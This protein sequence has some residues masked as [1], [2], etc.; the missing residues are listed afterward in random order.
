MPPKKGLPPAE[1]VEQVKEVEAHFQQW[2]SYLK[3]V[4]NNYLHHR[5]VYSRLRQFLLGRLSRPFLLLDLGCGDA[6]FMVRALEGTAIS[7]YVGVDLTKA[8]LALAAK[9]LAVLR[10]EHRLMEKDFY[11]IVQEAEIKADVIW[12]GLTF[13]HLPQPQKAKFLHL[14][15]NILPADGYLLMYEPTLL[16]EETRD[17][18]LGRWWRTC[19]NLWRAMTPEEL[20]RSRN[21]V[22]NHDFPEKLSTLEQMGRQQK[23]AGMTTLYQDPD[24]LYA[25]MCFAA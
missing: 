20:G 8:A 11:E 14:A 10:C 4:E 2:Q 15:H 23:F 24:K 25:M 1:Q 16:E 3:L 9:N 21:H 22:N 13:H 5:E 12:M 6:C 7:G 19:K 18:Y 17:Q